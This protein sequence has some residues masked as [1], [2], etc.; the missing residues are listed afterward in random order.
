MAT[1]REWQLPPGAPVT[2]LG[3]PDGRLL[4]YVRNPEGVVGLLDTASDEVTEW[5]LPRELLAGAPPILVGIAPLRRGY[6][7][8]LQGLPAFALFEPARGEFRVL[9]APITVTGSPQRLAIDAV[10]HVWATV[11]EPSSVWRLEPWSARGAVRL[12]PPELGAPCGLAAS[13][14][15]VWVAADAAAAQIELRATRITLY[16]PPAGGHGVAIA[17][18]HEV[19]VTADAVY[20]LSPGARPPA[21]RYPVAAA[22]ERIAVDVTGTAWFTARGRLGAVRPL[23]GEPAQASAETQ[24]VESESFDFSVT[25]ERARPAASRAGRVD[26]PLERV[27][28]GSV[29]EYALPAGAQPFDVVAA[30]RAVFYSDSARDVIGSLA[31]T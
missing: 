14:T 24:P 13:P 25:A 8:A 9:H 23:P 7:L 12:L 21:T 3:A 31:Y 5:A 16:A 28:T 30:G 10:G 4:A 2:Y 15:E 22:P 11:R 1:V 17:P 6:A 29:E 26:R 27:Q 18:R 20:R 19:W